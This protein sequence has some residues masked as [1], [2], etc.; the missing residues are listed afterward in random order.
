MGE[1][2]AALTRDLSLLVRQELELAKADHARRYNPKD[3]I[4]A[5]AGNIEFEA[6]KAEVE[7]CFGDWT[8]EEGRRLCIRW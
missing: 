3:S 8:G 1:V 7:R 2:A 6:V 5:L 4:L